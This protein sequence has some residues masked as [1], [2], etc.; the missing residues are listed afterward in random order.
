MCGRARVRQAGPLTP[1]SAVS[2]TVGSTFS[3]T[4]T[5]LIFHLALLAAAAPDPLQNQNTLCSWRRLLLSLVGLFHG[6]LCLCLLCVLLEWLMTLKEMLQ[7]RPVITALCRPLAVLTP[8]L[9]RVSL[10]F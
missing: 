4:Q 6:L 8:L 7:P 3:Y 1:P 10:G 5:P 2:C 9:G